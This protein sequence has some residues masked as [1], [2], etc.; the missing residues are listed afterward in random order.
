MSEETY[1]IEPPSQGLESIGPFTEWKIKLD[2]Y[3][4]EFLTGR[5]DDKGMFHLC[6]DHRMGIEIPKEH[7]HQ[8][9]WLIANAYAI[10]AG[11]SCFGEHSQIANPFKVKMSGITITPDIE[12]PVASE[13]PS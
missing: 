8:V 6:L 2:G 10:G 12:M 7:A 4:V 1:D 9:V 13:S 5:E 11:Y 3:A